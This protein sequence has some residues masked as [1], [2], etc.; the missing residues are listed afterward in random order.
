MTFPEKVI[1]V[2]Y[3]LGLSQ[4][5]LAAKLGVSFSTV[6]RWEKGHAMPSYLALDKFNTLCKENNIEFKE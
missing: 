3:E 6:N 2:R 1:K 4:E 5:K